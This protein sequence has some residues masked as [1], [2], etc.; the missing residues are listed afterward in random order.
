[1]TG[2]KTKPDSPSFRFT[3]TSGS[4]KLT[5]KSRKTGTEKQKNDNTGE[6]KVSDT[7]LSETVLSAA[8]ARRRASA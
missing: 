2:L 8:W 3:S 7:V 5:E 1:M 4:S 6:S